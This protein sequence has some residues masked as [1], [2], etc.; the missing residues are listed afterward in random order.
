[1]AIAEG[2]TAIE[3]ILEQAFNQGDLAVIDSLVALD[4]SARNGQDMAAL[5]RELKELAVGLR[6]AFP[7]LHCTVE[8]EIQVGSRTA[9]WWTMRGT[10]QGMLLGN[11][12]TGRT[13]RVEGMIHARLEEDRFAELRIL[14]D[15][16][17]ML[18]QL[19]LVP[20]PALRPN[21]Q[22]IGLEEKDRLMKRRKS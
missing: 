6:T 5:R 8:D 13:V 19:E 10:H 21:Q 1:M 22:G 7:D 9:A 14:V 16:L 11:R 3:G 4:A 20:P 17:G 15:R 2:R 12:P 18:Q